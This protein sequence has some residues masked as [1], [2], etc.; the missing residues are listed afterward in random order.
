MDGALDRLSVDKERWLLEIIVENNEWS[1]SIRERRDIIGKLLGWPRRKVPKE[2]VVRYILE[3]LGVDFLLQN[4]T[5]DNTTYKFHIWDTA[6]QERFRAIVKSYFRDVDVAIIMYD[7]TDIYALDNIE[8]MQNHRKRASEF[9]LHKYDG[10]A[11]SRLLN[12]LENYK[13]RERR[14]GKTSE[15]I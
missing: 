11:S 1:V 2:I 8:E 13:S 12:A 6:G 7:V 5:V 10:K 4:F 3:T 9:Y 14:F 15:Q